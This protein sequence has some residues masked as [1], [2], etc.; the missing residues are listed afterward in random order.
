MKKEGDLYILEEKK[1]V[2]QSRRAKFSAALNSR[3]EGGALQNSIST[4]SLLKSGR[5]LIYTPSQGLRTTGLLGKSSATWKT[6]EQ[7][8]GL[9]QMKAEDTSS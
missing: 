9:N 8:P 2:L 5:R 1:G 4:Q 3:E 6:R 7:D